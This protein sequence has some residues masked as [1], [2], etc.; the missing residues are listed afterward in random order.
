MR[1]HSEWYFTALA[2]SRTLIRMGHRP[3]SIGRV[4]PLCDDALCAEAASMRKD[5]GA[6]LGMPEAASS[7]IRS[8]DNRTT[9]LVC[10]VKVTWPCS[11]HRRRG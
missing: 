6:V 5:G 7:S 2:G 3:G 9:L 8:A 10:G 4:H 11:Q 1:S